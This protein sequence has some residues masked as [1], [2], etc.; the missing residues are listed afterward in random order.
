MAKRWTY[1]SVKE[2]FNSRGCELLETEYL[3]NKTKMRYI[4]SCGHEHRISLDNFLANKGNL[5]KACKYKDIAKKESISKEDIVSYFESEGVKVL[6]LTGEGTS[7]RVRYIA[8][9]GHKNV[10]DYAHFK[11]QRIGRIC[12]RCS[13]S[14]RYEYD[15]VKESF[16][17]KE[18]E[19]LET[20]YIN[21][22]APMKYIARCGHESYI[23][24]DTFL[25]ATSATLRCRKCH[26]HT[27]H[28]IPIDRNKTASKV[29]RKKVYERDKYTCIVCGK[30][31]GDLNAHHLESYDSDIEQRFSVE[32][33]VTL[34]PDCHILFHKAYGFGGNTK[35]Q[36]DEWVK[37]IPR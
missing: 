21:C 18:C 3:N 10:V 28:E 33:G 19:L 36:F 29:W 20:E 37:V 15:Y 1:D 31:G 14:I 22:K 4:A 8:K 30:H 5:C 26:K 9:C 13:K 34:C 11:S 24:F 12:N 17:N 6:D 7:S 23:T 2:L 25:N 16:E 27:Y 32:N 35:E